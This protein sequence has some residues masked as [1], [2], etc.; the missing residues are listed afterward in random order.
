[1]TLTARSTC[2]SSW[3]TSI[4]FFPG[5]EPSINTT[6]GIVRANT[7]S[8]LLAYTIQPTKFTALLDF[9]QTEEQ[10]QRVTV[11]TTAQVMALS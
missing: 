5:I 8:A 9:L 6:S 1:M 11:L 3:V 2:L 10:A 7:S 4:P